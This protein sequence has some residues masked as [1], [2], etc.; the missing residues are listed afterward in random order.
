MSQQHAQ[1]YFAA[2]KILSGLWRGG[3]KFGNDGG[4]GSVEIEEAALVMK[5]GHRGGG[6][7]FCEGGQVEKRRGLYRKIPTLSESTREMWGTRVGFVDQ[8][9][10]GF[11][12]NQA[13]LMG[14]CERGG[15]EGA[16][17]DGMVKNGKS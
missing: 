11:E 12:C 14:D 3:N 1:S 9:T 15:G 4:D 6:D 8:L 10:R 16:R 13:T 2:P 7:N 17:G 5:H